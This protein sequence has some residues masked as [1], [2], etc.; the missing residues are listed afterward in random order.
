MTR[1]WWE[2]EEIIRGFRNWLTHTADEIE[3][4]EEGDRPTDDGPSPD[5]PSWPSDDENT[6]RP[7]D[8][9]NFPSA[10]EADPRDEPAPDLPEVG[11][12]QLVEAF[13]AM[14][15]EL[16]LQTKG[17]RNL[18]ASVARSLEGLDAASRTF[19]SVQADEQE[20]AERAARPAV[21]ALIELD[22]GLRRA[23]Q[24]FQSTH[25]QMTQ[26]APAQ[27]RESLDTRFQKQPWWR[28][29][30]A[31]RWHEQVR[32]AAVE[33]LAR[34]IAEE[35]ASLMQGFEL[36]QARLAR[37][38]D[39]LKIGRL[40]ETGGPV[41]PSRMSVVELVHNADAPPE[42]VV[43]VV[44]PGYVW[45]ERVVRYAE[46]RAVASQRSVSVPLAQNPLTQNQP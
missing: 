45:G 6:S 17:S 7:E 30:A 36:I 25:H 1:S 33:A 37:T 41:D 23:Q 40:D 19:Q 2:N 39:R 5:E 32:E 11:L 12:L 22:E 26:S 13:T 16:K 18:E 9:G 46:V 35:F 3:A 15:H 28:R 42:T 4:M 38:L 31:R 44:R 24:A 27:L 34:S 14:R 10:N 8:G 21:E 29:L 20:A 43:E